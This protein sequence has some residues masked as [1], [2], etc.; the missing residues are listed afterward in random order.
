MTL[1]RFEIS[2]LMRCSSIDTEG[3]RC[4]RAPLHEGPHRWGR[5]DGTDPGG[6]R[7]VLPPNHPGEHALAWFDRPTEPGTRHN[8][9]YEG[10]EAGASAR[11]DADAR[12]YATHDWVPVSKSFTT[13]LPGR[14]RWLAAAFAGLTEPRGKLTVVYEYRPD[15]AALPGPFGGMPVG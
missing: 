14:L 3:F 11:A 4:V 9:R 13:G 12:V 8:V 2:D 15:E 6:H 10:T 7:C 1:S 5:C